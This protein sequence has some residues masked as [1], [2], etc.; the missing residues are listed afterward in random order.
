MANIAIHAPSEESGIIPRV[1]PGADTAARRRRLIRKRRLSW[2]EPLHSHRRRKFDRESAPWGLWLASPDF[3]KTHHLGNHFLEIYCSGSCH[4][5]I[6]RASSHQHRTP[7]YWPLRV[8]SF[9]S[10]TNTL[11]N[12]PSTQAHH[13]SSHPRRGPTNAKGSLQLACVRSSVCR[14]MGSMHDRI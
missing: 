5:R 1:L 4:F 7:F 13:G 6:D 9:L 8:D 2:L 14:I 10:I 12:T 3:D 11:E